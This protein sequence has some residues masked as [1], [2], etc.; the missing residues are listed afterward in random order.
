MVLGEGGVCYD[1]WI[2]LTKL[3][4]FALPHF[5]LRGQTC[6]LLQISLDFLPLQSSP[7]D[8]KEIFLGLV[9]E[10][11]CRSSYNHS[12]SASSA[13]VAGAQTWITCNI[14]WFALEMNQDHS[15][16]EIVPKHCILDSSDA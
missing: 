9:L 12:T 5:V 7:H 1:Q 13:L 16:F 15:V 4:A 8:E 10:G 2:L 6:L 14:E 3:L 11:V